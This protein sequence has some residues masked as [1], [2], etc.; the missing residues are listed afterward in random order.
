MPTHLPGFAD[1]KSPDDRDR[2]GGGDGGD[3]G[4]GD[5]D[6]KAVAMEVDEEEPTAETTAPTEAATGTEPPAAAVDHNVPP[7]AAAAA[8]AA[9]AGTSTPAGEEKQEPDFFTPDAV[10]DATAASARQISAALNHEAFIADL[11]GRYIAVRDERDAL[12]KSSSD[13]GSEV[14]ALRRAVVELKSTLA[15][16]EEEL[17]VAKRRSDDERSKRD[18]ADSERR[19]AD[20]RVTRM[21]VEADALREEISRLSESK[22]DLTA[23]LAEIETSSTLTSAS[24]LPLRLELE[25]VKTELGSITAHSDWLSTELSTRTEALSALRTKHGEEMAQL[26]STGDTMRYELDETKAKLA[27]SRSREETNRTDL[28]ALEERIRIQSRESVDS[29]QALE[30][31]LLAERRLVDMAKERA[32]RMASKYEQV[33]KEM[34]SMKRLAQ[35]AADDAR[36]EMERLVSAAEERGREALVEAEEEH[37]RSVR[38]LQNKLRDAEEGRKRIEDGLLSTPT[39]LRRRKRLAIAAADGS[40]DDGG[41]AAAAGGAQ[42]DEGPL[43]LTDLYEAKA[44]VE[45]ELLYERR[46]RARVELYLKKIQVDIESKTPE[47]RRKDRAYQVAIQAQDELKARLSEALDEAM[48]ARGEQQQVVVDKVRFETECRELRTENRDLAMQV[49]ALLR[50]QAGEAGDTG[51]SDGDD[52]AEI[53]SIQDLQ[54]RN[55]RLLREHRRLS[56]NVTKLEDK[57]RHDPTQIKLAESEAELSSLREERERQATLVAG[58]VQQRDLY[59][60]LLAKHDGQLVAVA[61]GEGGQGS[62]GS[63]LSLTDRTTTLEKENKK[64]TADVAKLTADLSTA[65]NN[66]EALEERSARLD[67]HASDL[68]ASVQ[69]LNGSLTVANG[70]VARATADASYHQERSVRLEKQ[71]EDFRSEVAS[72]VDARKELDRVN[73]S[74]QKSLAEARAD[75]ATNEMQLHQVEAKLRLAETQV[76]TVKSSEQRLSSETNSLRAELARQGALL[77]SVQ[78][79]EASLSAKNAT[80]LERLEEDM[81]RNTELL[82]SE[83]AKH[84]AEAVKLQGKISDLEVLLK[85][86]EAKKNEALTNMVKA[87]EDVV[88]A[89]ADFQALSERCTGLELSLSQAKRKLGEADDDDDGEDKLATLGADLESARN[90][91]AT[92]KE[93]IEDL[94]DIAKSNE[95]ALADMTKVSEEYKKKAEADLEKLKSELKASQRA[96]QTKQEMLDELGKDLA[97]SRGEQEKVVTDLKAKI[98]A[99]EA[100]AA[101]AKEDAEAAQSRMESIAS[102][103]KT[104]QADAA[105]AQNNYERELALHAAART[106]LRNAREEHEGEIRLRQSAQSQLESKRNEVEGEK[107]IWEE[108]KSKLE[109]SL[110]ET[111]KR[112][113]DIRSQNDLLHSQMESLTAT[114]EKFQN[115]KIASVPEEGAEGEAASS[116]DTNVLRK[117]VTD[118]REMVRFLR[119]ER[120]MYEAQLESARRTS[121]RERAAAAVTKRTLEEARAEL[122]VLQRG[123][124]NVDKENVKSAQERDADAAK[125]RKAEE[126]LVLL[127][128]SNKLL[129]EE[130]EKTARSLQEAQKE[131]DAKM[132]SAAPTEAKC[133][134]LE[135]DKAALVAEKASLAREV[136]AWKGRV[137]SLVS[138]FNTIDPEEHAQAL[139]RAEASKKECESLKISKERTE[140]ECASA[141]ALVSR[142]NKE[143]AQRKSA[144]ETAK[145]SLVKVTAEKATLSKKSINAKERL[146]LKE[147]LKKKEEELAASKAETEAATNRVDGLKKILNK[148][149]QQS[150]ELQ[151]KSLTAVAKQ[152]EAEK[153]LE[154]EQEILKGRQA[155]LAKAQSSAPALAPSA[156]DSEP[157]DKGKPAA[158]QAMKSVVAAPSPVPADGSTARMPKVPVGGFKFA[159][160]SV[161]KISAE[162]TSKSASQPAARTAS[163]TPTMAKQITSKSKASAAAAAVSSDAKMDHGSSK[164]GA[165][166]KSAASAAAAAAA[167][168]A[169]LREKIMRR[170]KKV[171]ELTEASNNAEGDTAPSAPP[172]KR[173]ART[174]ESD[175]PADAKLAG[176]T[177]EG[178]AAAAAKTIEKTDE[179]AAV[180]DSAIES[181]K[182]E[183][184]NESID[185]SE[186]DVASTE[187]APSSGFGFGKSSGGG[188]SVFGGGKSPTFGS[189]SDFVAPPTATAA[190][191]GSSSTVSQKRTVTSGVGA[192]TSSASGGRSTAGFGGAGSASEQGE[193][194]GNEGQTF[195]DIKPP[196]SSAPGKFV[197]GSSASITLPMPKSSPAQPA[198]TAGFG[199]FGQAPGGAKESPFGSAAPSSGGTTVFGSSATVVRPAAD[200]EAGTESASMGASTEKKEHDDDAGEGNEAEDGEVEE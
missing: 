150:V 20:E 81:K 75:A 133:R 182:K 109:E 88:Q 60:A 44:A 98:E 104:Y 148:L 86:Q 106:E 179:D 199:T 103:M 183:S 46:E 25:R 138:K 38:Q 1:P 124:G 105:A 121:E 68:S 119:S 175:K 35:A 32:E 82:A 186:V 118:L 188:S 14:D 96:A 41:A 26:K 77:D 5:K 125:I 132:K 9:G 72:A 73:T 122:E 61:E 21:A 191:F 120:E 59:R 193:T 156:A 198:P 165:E 110:K 97:G 48:A 200:A 3:G 169:E 144:L 181:E 131:L 51:G 126:Q 107:K 93:R 84:S 16:R 112:L 54:E 116:E 180:K 172:K 137:Q 71:V 11:E 18:G 28:E 43:S 160:S 178:T 146:Q 40:D 90:E 78:R 170:K 113:E 15:E 185:E 154:K 187:A 152:H 31:E 141:K 161:N 168:A 63:A 27:A 34:E 147:A 36:A 45:D 92:A 7:H 65:K 99:L 80:D 173:V 17:A 29:Y 37:G 145:A 13:R 151:K 50:A 167:A 67:A 139:S 177:A 47:I 74:L 22:S 4:S 197:F 39:P 91:L 42:V 136:D 2:G 64:L 102:E 127:R 58:I 115:D 49:Q 155:E 87:K 24:A 23:K 176:S 19:N 135:V 162:S 12:R 171:E 143:L 57:L 195:L 184:G 166:G 164:K 8:G 108:T 70:D 190:M 140:K 94:Q 163:P 192:M 134:Q 100:Q 117:T 111:E 69:R 158:T 95:T 189:G 6:G 52:I 142:L 83:R 114:V 149:K 10:A 66:E 153:A 85:E 123:E 174:S 196:G 101:S 55:Q 89:R 30:E 62:A 56:Q 159:P 79:I 157:T 130:A 53:Q 76:E 194:D 129:R 33:R 128:E